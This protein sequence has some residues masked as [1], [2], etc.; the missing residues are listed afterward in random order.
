MSGRG[1]RLH[2]ARG[3]RTMISR[4]AAMT[5]EPM[6]W[7]P[8]GDRAVV[9]RRRARPRRRAARAGRCAAACTAPG[10]ACDVGRG[11]GEDPRRAA[12]PCA[13]ACDGDEMAGRANLGLSSILSGTS[14]NHSCVTVGWRT[15]RRSCA[16]PGPDKKTAERLVVGIILLHRWLCATCPFMHAARLSALLLAVGALLDGQRFTLI[17]LGRHVSGQARAKHGI[18]RIEAYRY[19][20]GTDCYGRANGTALAPP[21]ARRRKRAPRTIL[22][23][24]ESCSSQSAPTNLSHLLTR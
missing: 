6:R 13:R 17:D 21:S 7:R 9:R 23:L 3:I 15:R 20:L 14:G 24:S 2:P 10:P 11:V 22:A 4:R 12:G 5:L 19:P 16:S 18:K 8:L 1:D